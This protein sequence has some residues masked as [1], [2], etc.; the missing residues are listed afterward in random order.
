MRRPYTPNIRPPNPGE[1]ADFYV[2][3]P[4]PE[5]LPSGEAVPERPLNVTEKI[6]RML[7]EGLR[8]AT[9]GPAIR[10]VP[11]HLRRYLPS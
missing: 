2:D 6:S 9:P 7:M 5:R 10:K 11:E 1:D 4:E 3:D 8:E